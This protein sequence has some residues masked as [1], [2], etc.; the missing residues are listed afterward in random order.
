MTHCLKEG[1]D[2]QHSFHDG[3]DLCG[4]STCTEPIHKQPEL[5]AVCWYLDVFGVAALWCLLAVFVQQPQ[6]AAELLDFVNA[7][8]A[9]EEA[10]AQRG[11]NGHFGLAVLQRREAG[12]THTMTAPNH[13]ETHR[14]TD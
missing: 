14:H 1:V 4:I 2:D 5:D 12:G 6:Q 8:S 9:A 10:Q 7:V 3:C 13:T 11:S